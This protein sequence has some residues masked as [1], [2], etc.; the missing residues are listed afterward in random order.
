MKRRDLT[1]LIVDDEAAAREKLSMLLAEADGLRVV[2]HA[3]DG[4]DAL[5]KIEALHPDL[6]FLDI[7]MPG[8]DGL[9]VASALDPQSGPAIVFVTAFDQHAIDAFDLAAIDYLLKPF[10]RA[11]LDK[12]LAR[13]ARFVRRSASRP[14]DLEGYYRQTGRYPARLIFRSDRGN[15]MVSRD[16]IEWLESCG[17][18]VKICLRDDAFVA[19][20][21]LNSVHAQLPPEIFIR[22]HRSH[23]VNLRSIIRSVPIGKGDH[24]LIL[25]DGT[26]LRLSRRYNKALFNTVPSD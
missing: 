25:R 24:R 17:N 3:V 12:T 1:A 2:G 15:E 20:Q 21:T 26:E 4:L 6:V 16:D 5:E 13:V 7:K 23:V 9:A 8:L 19:R 10:D 22:V 14:A 18:Y 11:R